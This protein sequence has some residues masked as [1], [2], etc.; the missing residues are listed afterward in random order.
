MRERS[1]KVFREVHDVRLLPNQE[2]IDFSRGTAAC[3]IGHF[4]PSC[5]CVALCCGAVDA[6][7]EEA[8]VGTWGVAAEEV[9]VAPASEVEGVPE[10]HF[11]LST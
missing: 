6:G 9:V 5:A 10:E 3:R 1:V 7:L 11:E 8:L 4:A 2:G